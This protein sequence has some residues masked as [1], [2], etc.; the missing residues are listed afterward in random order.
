MGPDFPRDWG[1]MGFPPQSGSLPMA[2]TM[3]MRGSA[4]AGPGTAADGA[5]AF[6]VAGRHTQLVRA[7][8]LAL[9]VLAV[10]ICLA[11]MLMLRKSWKIGKGRL[12]VGQI[13]LTADDM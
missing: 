10:C 6:R 7:L 2:M 4:V 8:R 9:P 12:D 11:Y 13:E 3:D 5:R 1:G